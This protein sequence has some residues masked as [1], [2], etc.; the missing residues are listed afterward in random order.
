[1]RSPW[2]QVSSQTG[3]F[4]VLMPGK[5]TQESDTD[6]D[7]SVTQNFTVVDG[8]TVYLVIYSDI[9]TEVTQVKPG[10]IFDRHRR[11]LRRRWRSISQPARN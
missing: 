1:M 10:E 11:W 5:P 7:G 6:A 8:E 4:K 2:Q 9:A 3:N